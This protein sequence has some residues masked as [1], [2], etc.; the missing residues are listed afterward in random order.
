MAI[1]WLFQEQG[2]T[3]APSLKKR[4]EGPGGFL[5]RTTSSSDLLS[6]KIMKTK[7]LPVLI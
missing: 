5:I 1:A 4:V 6:S 2:I 3:L 7:W